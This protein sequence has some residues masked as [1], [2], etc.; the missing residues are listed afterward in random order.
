MNDTLLLDD[1]SV[2]IN[3]KNP[4]F[5]IKISHNDII[6]FKKKYPRTDKIYIKRCV[7]LPGDTLAMQNGIVR[8][9]REIVTPHKALEFDHEIIAS[10]K[11][12]FADNCEDEFKTKLILYGYNRIPISQRRI[13]YLQKYNNFFLEAKKIS[14]HEKISNQ[15]GW[16]MDNFGEGII[17]YNGF[18]I[19]LDNNLLDWYLIAIMNEES[20]FN[21]VNG[22]YYIENREIKTYTFKENYYFVLGDN[23]H[24]SVDSRIYGLVSYKEI[25]GKT[26]IKL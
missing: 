6:T 16:D 22:K 23:R 4:V 10:D 26:L 13:E 1:I 3:V 18:R 12:L 11:S 8:L 7:A 2:S 19:Q 15:D 25:H 17:P 24:H 9:N 21:Y 14:N 20:K 5:S